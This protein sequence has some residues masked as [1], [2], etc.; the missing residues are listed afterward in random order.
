MATAT[1]KKTSKRSA[2]KRTSAKK[3]PLKKAAKKAPKEVAK[4]PAKATAAAAKAAAKG[5]LRRLVSTAGDA[6][7]GA[8][9]TTGDAVRD[10]AAKLRENSSGSLAGRARR[11]PIQ[12]SLDIAVPLDVA[13]EEWMALDFL[14]EGAHRVEGIERVGDD[15]L[16]GHLSGAKVNGDWEAQVLDEREGESFAWRSDYGSDCAGLVT[17]H[18]ISDRLTRLELQLDVVPSRLTEAT[19]LF[20]HRADHR[21]EADLRRFKARLET[22]NPTEYEGED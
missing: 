19:S 11:L 9:A 5:V 22:I 4:L 15:R 18:R 21:A 12:R 3:A 13:W 2:A 16:T 8:A 1:A 7:Q 14:P 20:L 17:F 6:I 10:A